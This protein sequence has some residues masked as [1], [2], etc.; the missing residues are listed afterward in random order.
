MARAR[1]R[2]RQMRRAPAQVLIA[3][4]RPMLRAR[5]L[6]QRPRTDLTLFQ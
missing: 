4:R 3:R 5:A 1:M 6:P 2:L